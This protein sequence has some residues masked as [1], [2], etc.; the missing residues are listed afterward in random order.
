M[1][2]REMDGI[3]ADVFTEHRYGVGSARKYPAVLT[4]ISGIFQKA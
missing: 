4:V 2:V 3:Q 1:G